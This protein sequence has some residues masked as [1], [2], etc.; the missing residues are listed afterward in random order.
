MDILVLADGRYGGF[1]LD[2]AAAA[3]LRTEEMG[4]RTR[5]LV[6]GGT[7]D[8]MSLRMLGIEVRLAGC[9]LVM[10]DDSEWIRDL[11]EFF[12]DGL[13][14]TRDCIFMSWI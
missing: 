12:G 3:S 13:P 6:A 1:G 2:S 14:L 10:S 8:E 11:F 9:S 4:G 5:L 7:D